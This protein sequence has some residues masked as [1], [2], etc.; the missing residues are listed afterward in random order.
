[1]LDREAVGD[2]D[3]AAVGTVGHDLDGRPLPSEHGDAHELEAHG[4]QSGRDDGGQF[5]LQGQRAGF[6]GSGVGVVQ[7][8]KGGRLRPPPVK[9]RRIWCSV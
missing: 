7:N 4:F 6:V 9:Q 2:R 3:Q 5:G 8:K 1:M